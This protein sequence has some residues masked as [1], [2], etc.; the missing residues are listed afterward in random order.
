MT[1]FQVKETEKNCD[2]QVQYKDEQM[3]GR[4]RELGEHYE[5]LLDE[6]GTKY[7]TL[8]MEKSEMVIYLWLFYVFCWHVCDTHH[9]RNYRLPVWILRE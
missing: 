8:K 3:D 6:A 9:S 4:I 1:E 7:E 2:Y 5:R